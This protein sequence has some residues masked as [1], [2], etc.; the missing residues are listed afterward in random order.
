MHTW[1]F[2]GA[3]S[4]HVILLFIICCSYDILVPQSKKRWANYEATCLLLHLHHCWEQGWEGALPRLLRNPHWVS[5]PLGGL[6]C[7]PWGQVCPIMTFAYPV[8]LIHVHKPVFIYRSLLIDSSICLK[9]EK[10]KLFLHV[11]SLPPFTCCNMLC[12]GL[13]SNLAVLF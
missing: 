11:S 10:I 1:V 7:L 4:G 6:A 5:L 13:C 3:K 2:K 8:C 12:H 9:T